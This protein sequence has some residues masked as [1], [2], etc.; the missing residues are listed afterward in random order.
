[1]MAA[2]GLLTA[3]RRST[4]PVA[5]T[6]QRTRSSGATALLVWAEPA[7]IA[8]VVI[9]ARSS[10]WKV[11]VFTPPTGED[12]LVR[13][14]LAHHRD[15]VAGIMFASGRMT[16]EVG[17]QPFLLFAR[18]FEAAYGPQL[19]GV[20]TRAGRPVVQPPDYAMYS[21]DF[22]LVLNQAL[23]TLPEL[24][25]DVFLMRE[26]SG[27]SYEEIANACELTPDAVR[28]RIHRA[29]LHLREVLARS[30]SPLRT[31]QIRPIGRPPRVTT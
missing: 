29:R 28:N 8:A 7:T 13:Q 12:P 31:T 16:A 11:P 2:A 15:W 4:R 27:L 14:Q 23:S 26:M 3:S 21:Y 22:M 6:H 9:A 1:M 19:V 10:G 18:S 25:R 20:K 17:P 24:D 30:L 5:S